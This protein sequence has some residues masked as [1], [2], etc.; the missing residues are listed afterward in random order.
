MAVMDLLVIIT[1]VILN[2]I[3]GIYF[4]NSLLS[5]TPA[6]SL[7]TVLI[8]AS[9]DCSVWLTVAFTC[10]RFVA[11]CHRKLKCRYC[12]E[13][14][15]V[16]VVAV[17]CSLCATKN[18]PFYFSYRPLYVANGVPWFCEIKLSF[19][20]AAM[21]KTYDWLDRILT[22]CLPFVLILFFNVLTIRHIVQS[23]R[24]RRLLRGVKE[25]ENR[26]D[27]KMAN[28]R[29]S[30]ILL[31]TISTSFLLLWITH[32]VNFIYVRILS[33]YSNVNDRSFILRE[34]A[35]MLSTLSF[36]T[37][38]FIY[39]ATQTSFRAELKKAVQYPL[40]LVVSY[41]NRSK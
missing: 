7:S 6:C 16:V 30:I 41:F 1:A 38:S 25:R 12:T 18:V 13:K 29:R 2:R 9:R 27:E 11:I 20:S 26:K 31:F 28:R 40:L 15:A 5:T 3:T 35:N 19:F 22:P 10:D 37:N 39:A 17:I 21:W 34:S 24:T 23:N 4:Y 14:T 32:L 36:C 33:G 8:F